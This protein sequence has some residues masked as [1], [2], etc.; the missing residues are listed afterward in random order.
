MRTAA[1]LSVVLLATVANADPATLTV[2]SDAFDANRTIP[3]EYT[4]DGA[5]KAPVLHWSA[6]PANTKSI[7]ILVDDPDAA[8]G[9]F[10]HALVTNVPPGD[11]V[12]DLGG[13]M[14]PG[15]TLER[16]DAGREGYLAPCPQNGVQHY[17]FRVYALDAPIR[18]ARVT[19]SV[20]REGFLRGIRGHVL[21]QGELVASY[22]PH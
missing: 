15:S 16:N 13:A 12:L 5:G 1:G 14:P 21:A 10:T 20:T 7:A 18:R 11:T 4:C 22:E 2:T 17:H 19:R 3:V 6:P 9:P 8:D